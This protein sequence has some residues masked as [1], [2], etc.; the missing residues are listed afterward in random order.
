MSQLENLKNGLPYIDDQE[1]Q[2]HMFGIKKLNHQYNH[3]FCE[4]EKHRILEEMGVSFKGTITLNASFKCDVGFNLSFGEDCFINYNSVFLDTGKITIGDNVFIGP[5]CSFYTPV[6]P[7]D[8]TQRNMRL[9][10]ALPIV[11]EDN[12][13]FGGSVVV[14]PGV[15]IGNGSVIGAGSIVTSDIP[16]AVL[17]FGNP[18]K[19]IRKITEA[20]KW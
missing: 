6:H 3:E 14:L 7:L 17:A 11:V 8:V 13:W 2:E 18:C 12:V 10:K 4:V 9:E 1:V 19:V 20:D 15:T 16:E 5:N